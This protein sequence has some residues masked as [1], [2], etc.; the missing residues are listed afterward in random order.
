MCAYC[1]NVLSVH[2]SILVFHVNVKYR[3]IER[4]IE[5]VANVRSA[6]AAPHVTQPESHPTSKQR[7]GHLL[8]SGGVG[9]WGGAGRNQTKPIIIPNCTWAPHIEIHNTEC[10][11]MHSE[12]TGQKWS[13]LPPAS[14]TKNGSQEWNASNCDRS[15]PSTLDSSAASN[16]TTDPIICLKRVKYCTFEANWTIRSRVKFAIDENIWL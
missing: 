1:S 5:R 8:L 9:D 6:S 16:R 14:R 3:G 11:I 7:A 12:W 10:N 15:A 2:C 13:Q 4:E